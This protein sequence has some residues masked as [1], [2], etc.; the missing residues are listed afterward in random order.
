VQAFHVPVDVVGYLVVGLRKETRALRRR[1]QQVVWREIEAIRRGEVVIT[2]GKALQAIRTG[3]A[4][5]GDAAEAAG[6]QSAERAAVRRVEQHAR[7][8]RR[9]RAVRQAG[10]WHA[11]RAGLIE[12][13]RA[14]AVLLVV[15]DVD[16]E[17]VA[18]ALAAEGDVAVVGLAFAAV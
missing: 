2:V 6:A 10:A 9:R 13:G 18:I 11:R 4:V 3:G 15:A 14:D 17:T 7:E 16:E 12:V 8:R 5:R 1:Q